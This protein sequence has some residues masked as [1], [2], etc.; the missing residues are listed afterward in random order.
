MTAIIQAVHPMTCCYVG[1][2]FPTK[3]TV[4]GWC[5]IVHRILRSSNSSPGEPSM[6]AYCP[7]AYCSANDG[8][9]VDF[10]MYIN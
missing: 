10:G 5:A 8:A 1:P 7:Y 3:V 6:P 2:A 9:V 4:Y